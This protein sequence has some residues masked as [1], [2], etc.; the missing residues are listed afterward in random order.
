MQNTFMII[1]IMVYTSLFLQAFCKL[2]LPL[3]P[4]WIEAK[5]G[6]SAKEQLQLAQGL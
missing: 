3:H 6:G 1:V 4:M 5:R 2:E